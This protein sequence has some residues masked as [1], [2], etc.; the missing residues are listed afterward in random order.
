M[1]KIVWII[2]CKMIY[3]LCLFFTAKQNIQN[4]ASKLNLNNHFIDTAFGFYKIALSKQMTKG[5]KSSLVIAACVYMVCR[6]EETPRI[7]SLENVR[8]LKLFCDFIINIILVSTIACHKKTRILSLCI[9]TAGLL[10][11]A[12]D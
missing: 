10:I 7:L 9:F 11:M 1:N 8:N 4:L 2:V 12:I 5:R 6:K 3:F